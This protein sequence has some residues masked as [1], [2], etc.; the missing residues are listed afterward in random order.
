MIWIKLSF[1]TLFEKRRKL[2]DSDKE[3]SKTETKGL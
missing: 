1:L 2:N 3:K